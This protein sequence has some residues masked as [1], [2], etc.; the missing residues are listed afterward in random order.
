MRYDRFDDARFYAEMIREKKHYVDNPSS[1]VRLKRIYRD[2]L[3]RAQGDDPLVLSLLQ[4]RV[5][6]RNHEDGEGFDECRIL[7]GRWA[8]EE[9]R[10]AID[11]AWIS[12]NSPYDCTG[13]IFTIDIYTKQTPV[14]LVWIHRIGV[15]V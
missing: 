13:Q 15:D 10:E 12:I 3:A 9:I 5:I 14:G 11:N 1:L 7:K 2:V 4:G 6:R 8:H